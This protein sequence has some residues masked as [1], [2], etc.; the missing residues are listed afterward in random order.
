MTAAAAAPG[1]GHADSPRLCA[2]GLKEALTRSSPSTT[3]SSGRCSFMLALLRF[4][5]GRCDEVPASCALVA[6]AFITLLFA[7]VAPVIV[8]D[9]ID[10]DRNADADATTDAGCGASGGVVTTRIDASGLVTDAPAAIAALP[11]PDA[12][13]PPESR[14]TVLDAAGKKSSMIGALRGSLT[15]L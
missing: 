1:V 8:V 15:A 11:L 4:L 3:T 6:E 13:P 7:L 9:A 14:V 5:E 10:D 2:S 12:D